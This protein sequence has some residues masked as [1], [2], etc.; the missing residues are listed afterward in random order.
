LSK[1]GK[2]VVV[3]EDG[4]IGSGETGRT[5]AHLM[6]ALDDRYVELIKLHGK[7]G[8]K[9]A[10]SSHKAAIDHIENIIKTEGIECDFTRYQSKFGKH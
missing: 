4:E 8:A 5:T 10:A 2:R 3:I 9:L 6:S 7:E 1:K